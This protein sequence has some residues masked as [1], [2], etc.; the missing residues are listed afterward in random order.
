M[1]AHRVTGRHCE[2]SQPPEERAKS[3]EPPRWSRVE[4]LPG[5]QTCRRAW[6]SPEEIH[7]CVDRFELGPERAD[8][9]WSIQLTQRRPDAAFYG[10]VPTTVDHYGFTVVPITLHDSCSMTDVGWAAFGT[11]TPEDSGLAWPECIDALVAGSGR[12]VTIQF[13]STDVE[14]LDTA[15][16]LTDLGLNVNIRQDGGTTCLVCVTESSGSHSP[17]AGLRIIRLRVLGELW[18]TGIIISS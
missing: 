14:L 8:S 6:F 12:V 16:D 13:P 17:T 11:V 2:A 3:P 10:T 1:R 7:E 15:Q 4:G 9:G 5:H 18:H